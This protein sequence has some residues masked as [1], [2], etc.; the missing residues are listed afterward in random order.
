MVTELYLLG[1][2]GLLLVLDFCEL[3]FSLS[4]AICTISLARRFVVSDLLLLPSRPP[5]RPK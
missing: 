5:P 4:R 1:L 2:S 3:L